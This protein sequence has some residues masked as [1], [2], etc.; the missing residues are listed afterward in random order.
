MR[1]ILIIL[2]AVGM[3][4][5]SSTDVSGA[6]LLQGGP[7]CL[8]KTWLDEFLVEA[9]RKNKRKMMMLLML[10]DGKC[11][12]SDTESMLITVLKKEESKIQIR[13]KVGNKYVIGWTIPEYVKE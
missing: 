7:V 13:M 12:M 9:G 8:T 2:L 5:L 11:Y 3:L 6:I 4:F 10:A 1:G